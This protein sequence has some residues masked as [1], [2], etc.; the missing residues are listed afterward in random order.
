MDDEGPLHRDD[1]LRE[2]GVTAVSGTEGVGHRPGI[3]VPFQNPPG[4]SDEHVFDHVLFPAPDRRFRQGRSGDY[5]APPYPRQV[6][7]PL[8]EKTALS[9]E[10]GAQ[11]LFHA[12]RDGSLF[13]GRQ[14]DRHDRASRRLLPRCDADHGFL[15]SPGRVEG[16]SRGAQGEEESREEED[17]EVSSLSDHFFSFLPAVPAD[18]GPRPRSFSWNPSFSRSRSRVAGKGFL[19][20]RL[21]GFSSIRSILLLYGFFAEFRVSAVSRGFPAVFPGSD[22]REAPSPGDRNGFFPEPH[23]PR[24]RPKSSGA[25]VICSDS[26]LPTMPCFLVYFLRASRERLRMDSQGGFPCAAI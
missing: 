4:R 18:S 26:A 24:E 11:I 17:R 21:P 6:G 7:D 16:R 2:P 12:D 25:G 8:F 10:E 5:D 1:P 19:S 22:L 3:H 9:F 15:S 14:R 13:E 23:P 20:L